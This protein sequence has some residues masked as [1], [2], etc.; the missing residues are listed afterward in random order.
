MVNALDHIELMLGTISSVFSMSSLNVR[1]RPQPI[2]DISSVEMSE[3][4][5]LMYA[6]NSGRTCEEG[7]R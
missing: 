1:G 6:A 3:D 7:V 5:S 4:F 2:R